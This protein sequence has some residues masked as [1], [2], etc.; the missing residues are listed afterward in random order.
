V[1]CARIAWRYHKP[2]AM[3]KTYVCRYC[4]NEF[5]WEPGK[6]GYV[7]ECR[8]CLHEKTT[9]KPPPDLIQRFEARYP[10]RAKHLKA[11]RRSLLN[12]GLDEDTTENAIK[13]FI[14]RSGTQI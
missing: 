3:P 13:D 14:I 1:E 11:L 5:L 9:V 7:D 6:P 4:Q 2:S 12:I 10:E 8:S